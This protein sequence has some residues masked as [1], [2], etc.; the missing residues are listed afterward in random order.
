MPETKAK[1]PKEDRKLQASN[2]DKIQR[3]DELTRKGTEA[4]QN[5]ESITLKPQKI[6][7][8]KAKS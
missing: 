1:Q 2:L 7:E 3:I 6:Y 5:C 4:A 8:T